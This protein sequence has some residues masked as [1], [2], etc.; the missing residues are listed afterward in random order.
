MSESRHVSRTCMYNKTSGV[1]HLPSSHLLP[2]LLQYEREVGPVSRQYVQ[3]KR[4]SH[5]ESK[6]QSEMGL[7]SLRPVRMTGLSACWVQ[8]SVTVREDAGM[9]GIGT[10]PGTDMG[11]RCVPRGGNGVIGGEGKRGGR[12][13][14]NVHVKGIER[15][16]LSPRA[17]A[18]G[19]PDIPQNE[20]ERGEPHAATSCTSH[21]HVH[22]PRPSYYV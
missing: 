11:M 1:T 15:A 4:N 16:D 17:S 10:W 13:E 19:H 3:H 12:S 22:R 8:N 7:S 9:R 2:F 5:T 14:W 18:V 6:V 21:T 20:E